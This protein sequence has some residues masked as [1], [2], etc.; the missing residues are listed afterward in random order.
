LLGVV[1]LGGAAGV[2]AEG[3]VDV[4]E[5]LFKHKLKRFVGGS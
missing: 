1:E 4:A 2:L 3:V 5:G